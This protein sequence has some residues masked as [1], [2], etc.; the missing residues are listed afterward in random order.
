MKEKY[1]CYGGEYRRE[2]GKGGDAAHRISVYEVEPE[3]VAYERYNDAL[4]QD[5][6]YDKGVNMVDGRFVEEHAQGKKDR[7]GKNRL[8]KEGM[9]MGDSSHQ[10]PSDIDCGDRPQDGCREGKQVAG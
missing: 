8:V 10:S 3:K 9:M 1:A 5:G 6:K 2:E 4:I 7:D